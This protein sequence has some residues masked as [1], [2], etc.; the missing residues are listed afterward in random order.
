M[1]PYDAGGGTMMV[2]SSRGIPSHSLGHHDRGRQL[3]DRPVY[4]SEFVIKLQS[5]R[6]QK[7]AKLEKLGKETKHGNARSRSTTRRYGD[8]LK[9]D[10]IEWMPSIN[11][12]VEPI[13]KIPRIQNKTIIN[14]TEIN[15]N[16]TKRTTV[17]FNSCVDIFEVEDYD[18][19][20]EKTW[21]RLSQLEKLSIRC[22]LND[23][24]TREMRVHRDSRQNT[25]LHRI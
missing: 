10:K 23:F 12:E 17:L 14:N 19:K 15:I 2:N 3:R 9:E 1:T 7:R 18:R 21:T 4:R 8:F 20:I 16:N 22:E 25:R 6:E 5:L 13:K 24:K 11:I